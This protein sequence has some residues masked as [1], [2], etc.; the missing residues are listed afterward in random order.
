[1]PSIPFNPVPE[2]QI[3][4]QPIGAVDARQKIDTT[5]L[6]AISGLG[7]SLGDVSDAAVQF[8]QIQDETHV[9]DVYAT[10]Y[11]E[12]ARQIKY[13]YMQK[14]GKDAVEGLPDYLGA[15][16]NLRT[17]VRSNLPDQ[18]QQQMFDKISNWHMMR[19]ADAM[20]NYADQENKVYRDQ[21]HTNLLGNFIQDASDNYNNPKMFGSSINS[22]LAEISTY[23]HDT[24]ASDDTIRAKSQAFVND[25]WS[26]MI[27]RQMTDNPQA[28]IDNYRQNYDKISAAERP[29]MESD[30]KAAN[31]PVW[32]RNSA[33]FIMSGG[34]PADT[35]SLWDAT[36]KVESGGDQSAI[37][38]KGAVGISQIMPDTARDVASEL[39]LPYDEEQ[40][41]ND[42]NYNETLGKRYQQDLLGRYGGDQTLAVAAYNA[43]PGA[44]DQ[45]LQKNGDPRQGGI[46][47]QDWVDKIPYPETKD[48]VQKVNGLAAP[49]DGT[50]MNKADVK[51]NLA[52]WIN[53]AESYAAQVAP[54]DPVF[55]DGLINEISAYTNRVTAAQ[56]GLT[57]KAN[58]TLYRAVVGGTSGQKPASLDELLAD[59]DA[60]QA[61][62][63]LSQ[64]DPKGLIGITEAIKQNA[65][66]QDPP[67][68]QNAADTFAKLMG[69]ASNDPVAFQSE[70][71]PQYYSQLPHALLDRLITMQGSI[72]KGQAKEQGA[73]LDIT[74]AMSVAK[75]S[76][77]GAGIHIPTDKS[78][79][80][81]KDTYNQFSG[82]LQLNLEQFYEN[83]KRR[84]N[85]KE[86]GDM[87][88]H[89]L[90]QGYQQGTSH[91][92]GLLGDKSVRAFQVDN[93]GQF[94]AP[95][96]DAEKPKIAAAYQ[97]VFGKAPTDQDI[98]DWYTKS[99]L[100]QG[101]Q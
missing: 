100:S 16:E 95:P 17:D 23:G 54:N 14:Q 50:P 99:V 39:K 73:A 67:Y 75:T 90:V 76:L 84:P 58:D 57:M 66:G 65:K 86:V 29:K 43:G 101:K 18:N 37:S 9:N 13:Q 98:Q 19:E 52:G 97:K 34:K 80:A 85:D 10:D 44:V 15:L 27:K 93:P 33:Q 21:T 53:H 32:I 36:T 71:L 49:Q 11:G 61:W 31:M 45:W 38:P 87:V 48:Y 82:K 94:Y 74:K 42:K 26:N 4:V 79:Q 8:K 3:D 40:L 2:G 72:S 1:M 81:T 68:T 12:R 91:L 77:M 5:G 70:N 28:A 20:S 83:N 56:A 51:G 92:F 24:G 47:H 88:N 78:P 25:A 7:K 30:L 63:T 6:Q 60:K 35:G 41:K 69:K 89:L 96:P 55:R 64:Q 22:G 62:I 59:P 46:S